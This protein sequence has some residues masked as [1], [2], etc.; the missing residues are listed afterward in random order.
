MGGAPPQHI[1]AGRYPQS[2]GRIFY[3][4]ERARRGLV[5]S[6]CRGSPQKFAF[7]SI[8]PTYKVCFI[9]SAQYMQ[10]VATFLLP[11]YPFHSYY[12]PDIQP[13]PS[14]L[15][16]LYIYPRALMLRLPPSLIY[17]GVLEALLH[18]LYK[19][20]HCSFAFCWTFYAMCLL[21]SRSGGHVPVPLCPHT[22]HFLSMV[23]ATLAA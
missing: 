4:W 2:H 1:L 7:N 15:C 11:W 19:I 16:P 9:L 21:L 14:Q 3:F 18:P 22:A 8:I 17:K 13:E 12:I 5:L 20:L 6:E 23:V 10:V